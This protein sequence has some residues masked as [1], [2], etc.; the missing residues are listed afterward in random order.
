MNELL[1]NIIH[2]LLEE[3]EVVVVLV[4]INLVYVTSSIFRNS[5][6]L[7]LEILI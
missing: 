5:N 2:K 3:E 4:K 7:Y 1:M 6:I